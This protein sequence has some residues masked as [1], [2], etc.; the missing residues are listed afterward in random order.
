MTFYQ[1][2][3]K[4]LGLPASTPAEGTE[5]LAKAVKD[6]AIEIGLETGFEK[7][8][9]DEK[10]WNSKIEEMAVLAY[11]DQCSPANPRVPL[12]K[13]MIEILRKAYKGID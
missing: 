4:L 1:E 12:V 9:I 11:E 13:D 5:S 2:I 7:L 3:A 10:D 8:G 6:L